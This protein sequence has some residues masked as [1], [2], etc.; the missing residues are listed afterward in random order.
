M[1][2]FRSAAAGALL[3]SHRAVVQRKAVVVDDGVDRCR[4]IANL[5]LPGFCNETFQFLLPFIYVA[6]V[7]V[8]FLHAFVYLTF[9]FLSVPFLQRFSMQNLRNGF[10]DSS[11]YIGFSSFAYCYAI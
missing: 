6:S 2:V 4:D 11:A 1:Y 8:M 5:Q 3:I 9:L 7:F 10:H